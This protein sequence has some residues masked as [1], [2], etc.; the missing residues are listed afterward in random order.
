[1]ARG[2]RRICRKTG[3]GKSHVNSHGYC[4]DHLSNRHGWKGGNTTNRGYGWAWQQ[5]RLKVIERDVG[6]CQPCKRMGHYTTASEVDHIQAKAHG[7]TDHMV[8]LEA[9]CPACHK[10][11]TQTDRQGRV[12]SLRGG[13]S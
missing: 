9:I 3:C 6:L 13:L 10:K 1:M 8:N 4:D 12:N 2:S 7:G 5:L 11:K